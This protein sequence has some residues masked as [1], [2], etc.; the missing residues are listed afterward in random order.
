MNKSKNSF[1]G[2][3]AFLLC[4]NSFLPAAADNRCAQG[5]VNATVDLT[6]WDDSEVLMLGGD[7]NFSWKP[8]EG[9]GSP[10]FTIPA[11]APV[12][13]RWV[14]LVEGRE[15]ALSLAKGIARYHITLLN[16]HERGVLQLYPGQTTGWLRVA[17]KNSGEAEEVIYDNLNAS[18]QPTLPT[19]HVPIAGLTKKTDLIIYVGNQ[20]Y[21]TG[22]IFSNPWI[23]TPAKAGEERAFHIVVSAIFLGGYLLMSCYSFF[24]WWR[25]RSHRLHFLL[26]TLSTALAVRLLDTQELISV[27]IPSTPLPVHWVLG[28][29]SFFLCV[30]VWAYYLRLA[31]PRFVSA[32]VI[33]TAVI[34]STIGLI[35][36]I[37]T[38]ADVYVPFGYSYRYIVV[39]VALMMIVQ[40]TRA[41]YA[42][43][44]GA[45]IT[46]ITCIITI[47]GGIVD[48][49]IYAMA[50]QPVMDYTVIG[51]FIFLATQHI[52]AADTYT[53]TLKEKADLTEEV[54]SLNRSLEE[55]VEERTANLARAMEKLEVQA[56]TDPLTG[57]Y[58]RRYFRECL[59]DVIKHARSDGTTFCL[60]AID[61]DFFKSINDTHGH[62][63]GD[64]AL[65]HLAGMLKSGVRGQDVVTRQ[66][67]EEFSIVLAG[68][69][70]TQAVAVLERI[71]GAIEASEIPIDSG[72]LKFTVSIGWVEYQ[73]DYG[74]HDMVVYTDKALYQA[75]ESGRNCVVRFGS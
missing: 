51:P 68:M 15:Q 52:L 50:E 25:D 3:I 23:G 26:A 64:E 9:A 70:G 19:D 43:V 65:V 61:V 28:W 24:V 37:F 46:L 55:K 29:G 2:L 66:G 48:I 20:D 33:Y 30:G 14:E 47:V 6:C 17:I 11:K 35:L 27:L 1:W 56:I 7:W 49:V 13:K 54:L 21:Y 62:D 72:K 57:L 75:K 60:A 4:A 32:W 53:K 74:A 16:G 12:P 8:L 5:V 39:F 36:V 31:F 38:S 44:R 41:A 69:D 59:D 63:V 71:R 45:L 40:L 22:A 10:N 67:G 18:G 58:N 34:P 73:P 42:K